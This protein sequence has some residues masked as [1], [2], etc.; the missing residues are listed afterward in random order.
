MPGVPRGGVAAGALLISELLRDVQNE[1]DKSRLVLRSNSK[2]Q[3]PRR[4]YRQEWPWRPVDPNPNSNK[5]QAYLDQLRCGE[6]IDDRCCGISRLW[7]RIKTGL[8]GMAT[9]TS[10]ERLTDTSPRL[11]VNWR[12]M[13]SDPHESDS[14]LTSPYP[15][16]HANG[17][18]NTRD[19]ASVYGAVQ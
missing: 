2:I 8:F 3:S 13:P 1:R 12:V 15:S 17:Y 18:R 14:A 10:L 11:V 6:L 7:K 19:L 16:A 9:A 5:H 4:S